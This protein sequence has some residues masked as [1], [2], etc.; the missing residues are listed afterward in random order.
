MTTGRK[1]ALITTLGVMLFVGALLVLSMSGGTD[2][3][4]PQGTEGAVIFEEA[5]ARCHGEN[6]VGDG[7]E[8]PRLAGGG[9]DPELVKQRVR[10]GEGRMPRFPNIRDMALE[11][12]AEHVHGL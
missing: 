5:C 6:G 2:E 1:M 11:N 12:L 8:G 4:L 9:T 10:V 7:P 3:Y